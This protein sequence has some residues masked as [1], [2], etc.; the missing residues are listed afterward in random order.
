MDSQKGKAAKK[1]KS[2][3]GDFCKSLGGK[4]HQVKIEV[5][6]TRFGRLFGNITWHGFDN[7]GISERQ[8]KVWDYMRSHMS[9]SDLPM[10]FVVYT[11]SPQERIVE[12]EITAL[13]NQELP[14]A[15]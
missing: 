14:W 6:E 8:N 3:L 10:V 7:I 13:A 9:R 5:G 1:L 4:P 12:E 15:K 11:K 2:V